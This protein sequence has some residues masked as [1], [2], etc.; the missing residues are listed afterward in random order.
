MTINIVTLKRGAGMLLLPESGL[1]SEQKDALSIFIVGGRRLELNELILLLQINAIEG[2]VG[3]LLATYLWG[4]YRELLVRAYKRHNH[5]TVL[6]DSL[7]R[8]ITVNPGLANSIGRQINFTVAQSN[9]TS[10]KIKEALPQSKLAVW[11]AQKFKFNSVAINN[12]IPYEFKQSNNSLVSEN[13]AAI[14]QPYSANENTNKDSK[15]NEEFIQSRINTFLQY[16]EARMKSVMK[17]F[18]TIP[19]LVKQKISPVVVE[20]TKTISDYHSVLSPDKTDNPTKSLQS[21]QAVL[22]PPQATESKSDGNKVSN[23][24]RSVWEVLSPTTSTISSN[25]FLSQATR[26]I[27]SPKQQDLIEDTESSDQIKPLKANQA[28]LSPQPATNNGENKVSKV[29]HS[30][31]A[32]LSPTKSKT[33]PNKLLSQAGGILSPIPQKNSAN[34][35]E[36]DPNRPTT[37]LYH[38]DKGAAGIESNMMTLSSIEHLQAVLDKAIEIAIS[39]NNAGEA[40]RRSVVKKLDF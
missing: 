4:S 31:W 38:T 8:V 39:D 35:N 7:S 1:S 17:F 11:V 9:N 20:K 25:K 5:I 40:P 36:F 26:D 3:S 28:V 37:V 14:N 34:E 29:M 32:I 33:P 15:E 22:S 19:F 23:T 18:D 27:L 13:I 10:S 24:L 30:M 6:E 16:A 2:N 21:Y 12:D